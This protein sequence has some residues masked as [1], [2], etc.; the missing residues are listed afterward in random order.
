MHYNV[1][2][3]NLIET[4]KI[5]FQLTTSKINTIFCLNTIFYLKLIIFEIL[6]YS[7]NTV[8]AFK[9]KGNYDRFRKL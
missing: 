5:V 4:N 8:F 3:Y 9:V 1:F 7:E 2:I 6:I